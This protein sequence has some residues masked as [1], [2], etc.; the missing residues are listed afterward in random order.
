MITQVVK[1][2]KRTSS[3]SGQQLHYSRNIYFL[4]LQNA[5]DSG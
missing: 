5:I 2:A 1:R 3:S 4:S